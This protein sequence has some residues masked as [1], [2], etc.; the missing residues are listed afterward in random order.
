MIETAPAFREGSH[1]TTDEQVLRKVLRNTGYR[2]YSPDLESSNDT[3]SHFSKRIY[4]NKYPR[5]HFIYHRQDQR[6]NLHL[7]HRPHRTNNRNNQIQQELALLIEF[8]SQENLNTNP[9]SFTFLHNVT[10]QL[11]QMALFGPDSNRTD[12]KPEEGTTDYSRISP[13][14]SRKRE[15]L[16]A[17][18]EL[19]EFIGVTRFF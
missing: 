12:Q 19:R 17:R 2:P 14:A 1:P 3:E 13:I 4:K 18:L 7:D 16:Q 6:I 5:F 11:R 10:G 8:F 9:K 15:R